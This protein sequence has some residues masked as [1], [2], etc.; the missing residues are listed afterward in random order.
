MENK[1]FGSPSMTRDRALMIDEIERQNVADVL[2]S[3]LNVFGNFLYQCLAAQEL[4]VDR[5]RFRSAFILAITAPGSTIPW[6]RSRNPSSCREHC[7]VFLL[8]LPEAFHSLF[9]AVRW[10][11]GDVR[12]DKYQFDELIFLS[13]NSTFLPGILNGPISLVND[14]DQEWDSSFR[15]IKIRTKA[16]D[17]KANC[18][19]CHMSPKL[20]TSCWEEHLVTLFCDM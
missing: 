14:D 3:C 6:T 20:T 2:V 13:F 1:R 19:P 8:P 12:Y 16:M 11:D 5:F 10:L 9:L 18:L 15:N 17:A 7:L 4:R